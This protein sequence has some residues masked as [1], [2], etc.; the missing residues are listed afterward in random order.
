MASVERGRR[1]LARMRGAGWNPRL[2]RDRVAD[3]ALLLA[4]NTGPLR[5]LF[6]RARVIG[7]GE[8][9]VKT[10]LAAGVAWWLGRAAGIEVPLLATLTAMFTIELTLA[11]TVLGSRQRLAG[12]IVGLGIA[13]AL[14]SFGGASGATI[15]VGVAL[16][17]M[18]GIRLRL[19]A[20]GIGQIA[21]TTV[22]ALAARG[23]LGF[24]AYAWVL[25]LNTVIGMVVGVALNLLVAPPTYTTA[26]L[27]A[28]RTLAEAVAT[29]L[30]ELA[31]GLEHGMTP[32]IAQGGLRRARAATASI[33]EAQR[34]LERADESVKYHLASLSPERTL[35][36][37]ADARRV[38]AALEHAAIQARVT[39]RS[40]TDALA[41][42]PE[43]GRP[44]WLRPEWGGRDLA[45]TVHAVAIALR[46]LPDAATDAEA[47]G[48]LTG[49]L[50][51]G[52]AAHGAAVLRIGEAPS[53]REVRPDWVLAG[54]VCG[55][56][57]Q[58][59][60]DLEA[61]ATARPRS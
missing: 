37:L 48:R 55:L 25:S 41:P 18:A 16:S 34:A 10:A 19:D 54:E 58:L 13:L 30:D 43:G 56:L 12:L 17:L 33:Q 24:F 26:A 27:A 61:A 2:D 36:P 49:A 8:R 52:R 6:D 22:L 32:A 38:N 46:A 5:E 29:V 1:G 9:V 35:G 14:S 45:A 47:R 21:S 15:V 3:A 7:L 51:A 50:A 44:E 60:H 23:D 42:F 39:S 20:T 57:G 11:Q 31:V 40:L 28:V 59:L 53:A 4:G